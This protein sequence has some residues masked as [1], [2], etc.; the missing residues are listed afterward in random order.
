MG[1][2][3]LAYF[4]F[5]QAFEDAAER[6]VH[7]ALGI[8]AEVGG[9]AGPDGAALRARI[10]IATGL[11][12]VGEIIGEGLA[13]ERSIVGETP[14]LAARLQALAAPGTIVIGEATQR[15]LGGLF[16]LEALGLHELKGF[17][18]PLPAWRIYGEASIECRFAAIRTG[19]K[20]PL[21][22]RAHELGLLLDRWRLARSGEGQIVTVIGEAGI[23]KSRAI[24]ALQEVIASEPKTRIHLQCSP[25]HNE[26]A[27]YPLI[28]HLIRAAR[29]APA[30][31]PGARIEKLRAL[32]ADRAASD[33]AAIPL[34]AELL[35][36]ADS[37][38]HPLPL[39]P[40][41]CK[42][43]TIALLVDEIVRLT[44]ADPVLLVVE[45]AH[46]IDATT[47]ELLTRLADG[48][49]SAR[50]LAIVTARPD[51]AP[52]WQARPQGSLLT[53]GR[54]GRADCAQMVAAVA[55]VHGLSAETVAAIVAKTDGVPLFVEE[56][57]KS[58]L[59][60]PSE[61]GATVPTH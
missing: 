13:Q 57:T 37:P 28:R 17:A 12:V 59:E 3:V 9:L 7:A 45:D 34:P 52:P 35:S 60:S 10:G 58:V 38:P 33:P 42:T 5:P 55:A 4:G 29:I 24:A 21:S 32:V 15:L 56:L 18:R 11:V 46:W 19:D 61:N 23:G 25:H 1:D 47:L 30:D 39:S 43:A 20:L 48:V 50:V 8:L 51:F 36:I 31:P 53:S 22:G 14:S 49:G 16:D 26:S 6:A 27:L 2:G 41:Q 40:A 44:E 54:L